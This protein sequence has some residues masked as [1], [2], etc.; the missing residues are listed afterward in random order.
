MIW[1]FHN[2]GKWEDVALAEKIEGPFG[3]PYPFVRQVIRQQRRCSICN[4]VETKS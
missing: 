2:Y 3:W 1:H 4:R